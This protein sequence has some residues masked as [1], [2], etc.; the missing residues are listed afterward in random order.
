MLIK[1]I[2]RSEKPI[3][4][5]GGCFDILH[6]GHVRFLN[7]AKKYGILI[8]ALE[9]DSN[10]TRLKGINRPIHTQLQ[11]AEMLASMKSVDYILLLPKLTSDQDYYQ[12]TQTISPNIIAVTEKDPQLKNKQQQADQVGAKIIIISKTQT[13]TTSLLIKL[14]NLENT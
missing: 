3:V 13:P 12:L 2:K 5:A 10:L 6:L 4:L 9:S 14:L 7:Q 11:R 1:I 8:V